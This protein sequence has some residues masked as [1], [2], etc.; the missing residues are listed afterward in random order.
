MS[1]C[2]ARYFIHRLYLHSPLDLENKLALLLKYFSISH[3]DSC[4]KL[5][6]YCILTPLASIANTYNIPLTLK[7]VFQTA[8]MG[9]LTISVIAS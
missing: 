9:R 4:N 2:M 8:K 3:S 1:E 5:F 6:I 7:G